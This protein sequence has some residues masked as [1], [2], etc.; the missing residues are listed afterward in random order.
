MTP[1]RENSVNGKQCNF[2]HKETLSF[3]IAIVLRSFKG[4]A[5]YLLSHLSHDDLL[6]NTNTRDYV[7]TLGYFANPVWFPR[8]P[9]NTSVWIQ[10]ESDVKVQLYSWVSEDGN[11]TFSVTEHLFHQL[12]SSLFCSFDLSLHWPLFFSNL[13]WK[14]SKYTNSELGKINFITIKL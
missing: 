5:I 12:L 6:T 3:G 7:V 2:I 8:L 9:S 14:T 10:F 4:D 13:N 1:L 11:V